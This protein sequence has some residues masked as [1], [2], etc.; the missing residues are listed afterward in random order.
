MA[1]EDAP[2]P[3]VI[4]TLGPCWKQNK[5]KLPMVVALWDVGSL[6]IL[7]LY[8][9][10]S[11]MVQLKLYWPNYSSVELSQFGALSKALTAS[12]ITVIF[13]LKGIAMH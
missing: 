8:I 3:S 7:M 11:C 2:W 9:V 12:H 10:T 1:Q 6:L 5:V 13:I 4:I